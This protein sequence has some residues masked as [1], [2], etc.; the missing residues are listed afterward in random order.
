MSLKKFFP[1][2]SLGESIPAPV[3]IG[4]ILDSTELSQDVFNASKWTL[5]GAGNAV[6]ASDGITLSGNTGL[7]VANGLKSTFINSLENTIVSVK[8]KMLDPDTAIGNGYKAIDIL[9]PNDGD[10]Y[11]SLLIGA[12]LGMFIVSAQPSTS[13]PAGLTWAQND[14][15]QFDFISSFLGMTGTVTNLDDPGFLS[16]PATLSNTYGDSYRFS[17]GARNLWFSNFRSSAKI[18]EI[19]VT[20]TD[21][22]YSFMEFFGTSKTAGAF[23]D[24][25]A[26]RYSDMW[27]TSTGKSFNNC[28]TSSGTTDTLLSQAPGIIDRQ[29]RNLVIE[30]GRN[31]VANGVL[32]ATIEAKINSFISQIQL[33]VTGIKMYFLLV[34]P[35]L[36]VYDFTTINA[37]LSTL[38]NG[39]DIFVIDTVTGFN[40]AW[41]TPDNVHWLPAAH[42]YIAGKVIAAI[43]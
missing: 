25:K 8:I 36:T 29:P 39:T 13:A 10:Y 34:S 33:G 40:T 19:K 28:A 27:G 22:K 4:I 35:E 7:S 42:S 32:E 31:D 38:D 41:L 30:I 21:W 14:T 15:L 5:V 24:T 18:T 3:P 26:N 11:Y 17:S 16:L 1:F 12:F 20:S 37:F 2:S 9:A 6:Y 23:C 43:P